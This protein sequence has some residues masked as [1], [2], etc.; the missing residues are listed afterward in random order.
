MHNLKTNFDEIYKI[1]KSSLSDKLNSEDN[2]QFYPRKQKMND[3]SIITFPICAESLGIDSENYLWSKLKKDYSKDFPDLID[4][5]NFNKRRRRLHLFID[6]VT[7]KLSA[8]LN[9]EEDVFIIGSIGV[10]VCKIAREKAM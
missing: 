2:L 4:R 7:K 6:E 10:P 5:S 3:C 8:G 1:V 9:E